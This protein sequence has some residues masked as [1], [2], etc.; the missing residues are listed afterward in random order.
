M[1]LALAWGGLGC[2]DEPIG[3][4]P[5]GCDEP[6]C[7]ADP[8]AHLVCIDACSRD[9]ECPLGTICGTPPG[10]GAEPT[11]CTPPRGPHTLSTALTEGFGVRQMESTLVTVALPAADGSVRVSAELGWRAPASTTVVTCALFACPPVVDDGVIVNYDQC[12]LARVVSEQSVGSFSLTDGERALPRPEASTTCS[13]GSVAPPN[14]RQLRPVTELL[15]GCWAYDDTRLIAATRLRRPAADEIADAHGDFD[16]DCASEDAE[17]RNCV[18]D[19]GT[20]GGCL[21][22]ACR[23]RCLRDADCGDDEHRGLTG[24]CDGT[25]GVGRLGL[26]VDRGP[27]RPPEGS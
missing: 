10:A 18:L 2:V 1:L 14:P 11:V 4:A 7:V 6:Q 25:V 16:L 15:A 24:S 12:V 13:D 27:T 8:M 3:P 20:M 5:L 17:G 22:E 21:R 23:R 19:D 9:D 26:C